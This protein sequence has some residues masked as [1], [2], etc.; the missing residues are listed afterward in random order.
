[1]LEEYIFWRCGRAGRQTQSCRLTSCSYIQLHNTQTDCDGGSG[2][3]LPLKSHRLKAIF[4]LF[5][6]FWSE[7]LLTYR[8]ATKT[9]I[10]HIIQ[11]CFLSKTSLKERLVILVLNSQ[12]EHQWTWLVS[13]WSR[14][15]LQM[16]RRAQIS[17]QHFLCQWIAEITIG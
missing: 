13:N 1:M 8:V 10:L 2:I 5:F 6:Y 4:H 9:V 14:E 3:K 17:N 15:V 11:T 16:D 7:C 12:L